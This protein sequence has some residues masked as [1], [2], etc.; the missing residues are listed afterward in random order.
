MRVYISGDRKEIEYTSDNG[1]RGRMYGISSMRICDPDGKEVFHT[2]F[3]A[4]NTLEELRE[5][6]DTMPEFLETLNRMM[7]DYKVTK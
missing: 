5:I 3:R 2:H 4:A 1:Y 6:V 7:K